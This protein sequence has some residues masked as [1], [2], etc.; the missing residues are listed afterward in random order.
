[1]P[2]KLLT[3]PRSGVEDLFLV[4]SLFKA[5]QAWSQVQKRVTHLGV[6]AS[7]GCCPK[8]QPGAPCLHSGQLYRVKLPGGTLQEEIP[9]LGDSVCSLDKPI[10]AHAPLPLVPG[11]CMA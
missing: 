1:M 7:S 9:V 8:L 5:G 10:G 4:C 6:C 3:L 11:S 2:G